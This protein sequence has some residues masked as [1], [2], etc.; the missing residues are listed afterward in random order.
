MVKTCLYDEGVFNVKDLMRQGANEE[1]LLLAIKEAVQNKARDGFEAEHSR[2]A[3]KQIVE[4]M[5]VI[6]G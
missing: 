5:S 2:I 1:Q 3:N 4:S 6:G